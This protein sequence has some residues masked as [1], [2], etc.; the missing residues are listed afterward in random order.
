MMSLVMGVETGMDFEVV[1][2]RVFWVY[3]NCDL[4]MVKV[5]VLQ[6][7]VRYVIITLLKPDIANV[8]HLHH[9]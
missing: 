2:I 1:Q 5:G 8:L 4:S 9:T 7:T 6:S 3:C